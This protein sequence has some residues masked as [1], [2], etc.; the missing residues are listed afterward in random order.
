MLKDI[1]PQ[2]PA[3]MP[4]QQSDGQSTVT[5]E[6]IRSNSTLSFCLDVDATS[7]GGF[8]EEADDDPYNNFQFS[9]QSLPSPSPNFYLSPLFSARR[10]LNT[11][12][13]HRPP[14]DEPVP[15]ERSKRGF[16]SRRVR[17][18]SSLELATRNPNQCQKVNAK[19][20]KVNILMM[21]VHVTVPAERKQCQGCYLGIATPFQPGAQSS[22]TVGF[23]PQTLHRT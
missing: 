18:D 7:G 19:A 21:A 16:F 5:K 23:A 4:P 22:H 12:S 15:Q 10:L 11:F 13:R 3:P 8:T 9:Q 17:S 6:E 14:P 1:A 20:N 2:L